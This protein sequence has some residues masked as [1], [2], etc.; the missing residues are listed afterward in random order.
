MTQKFITVKQ[1]SEKLANRSRSS[2]DRDIKA[3]RLPKPRKFGSR[4]YWIESEI[5]RIIEETTAA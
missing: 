5:D 2:I 4:S 3:G 1:L